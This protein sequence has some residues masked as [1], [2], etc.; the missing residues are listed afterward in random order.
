MSQ[1][2]LRVFFPT[3]IAAAGLITNKLQF[4]INS[5]SVSLDDES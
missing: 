2:R 1:S 4:A 3:I 5:I